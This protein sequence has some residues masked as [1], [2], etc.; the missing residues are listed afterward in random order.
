MATAQSKRS[1]RWV[2]AVFIAGDEGNKCS[3]HRTA[4]ESC[5]VICVPC[6]VIAT[7]TGSPCPEKECLD[8]VGTSLVV[9]LRLWM[10]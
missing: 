6:R 7:P 4:Q 8:I 1:P 3:L 2:R 10:K 5:Y 9:C